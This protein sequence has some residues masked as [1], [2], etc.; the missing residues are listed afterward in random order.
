MQIKVNEE[1]LTERVRLV[2][3]SVYRVEKSSSK[4]FT[5]NHWLDILR[6]SKSRNVIEKGHDSLPC[7]GKFANLNKADTQRLLSKLINDGFL[8]EEMKFLQYDNIASY[9]RLGDKAKELQSGD[10]KFM[11]PFKQQAS[12]NDQQRLPQ[13]EENANIRQLYEIAYEALVEVSK[14]I[15]SELKGVQY[16]LIVQLDAL[17]EIS[18]KL[19][20]TKTEFLKIP[21]ITREFFENHGNRYLEVTKQYRLMLDDQIQLI[22]NADMNLDDDFD[23][24]YDESEN[25]DESDSLYFRMDEPST[26]TGTGRKK[27]S[28]YGGSGGAKRKPYNKFGKSKYFYKKKKTTGNNSFTNKKFNFKKKDSW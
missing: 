2:L 4:D 1:D 8:R 7:Y 12:R 25:L 27:A 9:M 3:Q 22:Q 6:G 28:N 11:F 23:E 24:N 18:T 10:R 19:P 17:R 14:A 20:T 16:H 26:S 15:A 21:S 5:L 13:P